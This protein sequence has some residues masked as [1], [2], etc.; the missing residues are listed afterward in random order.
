LDGIVA[1]LPECF[2]FLIHFSTHISNP[3]EWKI[4]ITLVYAFCFYLHPGWGEIWVEPTP[5]IKC[6]A[7]RMDCNITRK[8]LW[9]YRPARF[10]HLFGME[11]QR[12]KLTPGFSLTQG[13]WKIYFYLIKVFWDWR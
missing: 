5:D 7:F 10:F 3:P 13:E 2:I 6:G 9:T 8:T 4:I 1:I 12:G 11:P